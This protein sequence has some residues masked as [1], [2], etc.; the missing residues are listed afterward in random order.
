M[1]CAQLSVTH[2]TAAR[3]RKARLHIFCNLR[4][5]AWAGIEVSLP[6]RRCT[7][8][9]WRQHR[10]ARPVV[11]AVAPSAIRCQLLYTC[12]HDA[13]T[14]SSC[15]RLGAFPTRHSHCIFDDYFGEIETS[16]R[17]DST[18]TIKQASGNSHYAYLTL[19]HAVLASVV[20]L[21][22]H[23]TLRDDSN[24]AMRRPTDGATTGKVEATSTF[25]SLNSPS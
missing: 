25:K 21:L 18:R 19:E 2:T 6:R 22:T 17:C 3:W 20:T 15:D 12:Q 1:S 9:A 23:V 8:T 7:F 11:D 10:S 4:D 5:G 24:I 14:I 16:Q 13:V